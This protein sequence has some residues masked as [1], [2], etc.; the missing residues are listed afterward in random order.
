MS[1]IC[2]LLTIAI[3][4]YNRARML[5]DSLV[6]LGEIETFADR[7]ITLCRSRELRE[8]MG[9]TGRSNVELFSMDKVILGYSRLIQELLAKQGN[10]LSDSSAIFLHL[11]TR[12]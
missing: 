10:T 6:P 7:L 4:T 9:A 8:K 11:H 1:S 3:L 2:P 12:L 5:G